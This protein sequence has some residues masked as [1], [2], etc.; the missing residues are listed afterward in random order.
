MRTTLHVASLSGF[1]KIAQ[2]LIDSGAN[3]NALDKYGLKPSDLAQT[4]AMQNLFLLYT[5]PS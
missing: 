1:V 5:N 4:K 2:L 3:L